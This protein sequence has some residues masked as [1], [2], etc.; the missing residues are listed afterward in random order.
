MHKRQAAQS[1]V[2]PHSVMQWCQLHPMGNLSMLRPPCGTGTFVSLPQVKPQ[3]L[4]RISSNLHQLN[5]WCK[6][7][8][9]CED[10]SNPEKGLGFAGRYCHQSHPSHHHLVSLSTTPLHPSPPSHLPGWPTLVGPPDGSLAISSYFMNAI[11]KVW[12]TQ[13]TFHQ[14]PENLGL[15]HKFIPLP[16]EG[17]SSFF[18]T[19]PD[20]SVFNTV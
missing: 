5:S 14:W 1:Y 20:A 2:T 13:R 9:I 11:K 12:P 4:A 18:S 6:F 7:R 3:Q 10:I 15:G 17:P 16:E 19:F 8:L